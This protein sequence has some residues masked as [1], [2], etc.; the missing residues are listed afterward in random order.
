MSALWVLVDSSVMGI[1]KKKKPPVHEA[2][3]AGLDLTWLIGTV[4]E[5]RGV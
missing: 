5:T 2:R 4:E 3:A 1:S